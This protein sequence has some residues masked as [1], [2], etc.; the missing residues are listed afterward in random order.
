MKRM[1]NIFLAVALMWMAAAAAQVKTLLVAESGLPYTN[2]TWFSYGS[3]NSIE[4]SDIV[5]CWNRGLRIIKAAY[6]GEGWMVILAANTGYTMQT[7]IVS[8]EWPEQWLSDKLQLGYAITALSHSPREWLVVLSQGSGISRQTIWQDTWQNLE[9]WIAE[10]KGYGYSITD[11][12]YDGQGWMV[13]MS[14]D[15]PY[16][17]Q[18]YFVTDSSNDMMLKIPSEVWGKGYNIHQVEYGGGHYIVTFGNYASGDGRFQ[19]LQVD[20]DNAKGY[21]REQWEKGDNIAYVGGGYKKGRK[22]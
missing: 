20:P 18:G 15:S 12:A 10:Q 9:P 11:L 8:E 19:N 5:D 4:Q 16:T 21:I 13:V 1:R 3:G 17:S 2:Q 6:T 22:R 7:Y 14:Q